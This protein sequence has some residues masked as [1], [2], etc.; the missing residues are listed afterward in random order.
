VLRAVTKAGAL[1]VH[2]LRMLPRGAV[3]SLLEV[4][5]DCIP[6]DVCFVRVCL[7]HSVLAFLRQCQVP[8]PD[9]HPYPPLILVIILSCS[10]SHKRL[11]VYHQKITASKQQDRRRSPW[12][13]LPQPINRIMLKENESSLSI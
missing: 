5:T 9:P 8:P 11:L 2:G 6:V 13:R 4:V 7:L 3:P 12:F 1:I 10:I